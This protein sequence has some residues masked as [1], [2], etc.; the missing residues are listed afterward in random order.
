MSGKRTVRVVQRLLEEASVLL[1]R[2]GFSHPANVNTLNSHGLRW[3]PRWIID[4]LV[5][6]R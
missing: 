2:Y 1:N 6:N 5:F 4:G 3:L